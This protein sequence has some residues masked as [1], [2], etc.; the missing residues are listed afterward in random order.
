MLDLGIK[1]SSVIWSP[2]FNLIVV[3]SVAPW[4]TPIQNIENLKALGMKVYFYYG[5]TVNYVETTNQW[6]TQQKIY[7][8]LTQRHNGV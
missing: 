1:K 5:S 3:S 7:N 6:E 8:L 4:G 2:L